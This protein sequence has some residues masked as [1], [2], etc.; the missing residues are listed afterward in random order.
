MVALE[1]LRRWRRTM[2]RVVLVVALALTM[3]LLSV[4]STLAVG[5]QPLPLAAC[6]TGTATA[7]DVD[8]GGAHHIA[9]LH[10]FDSDGTWACYHRNPTYPP[11]GPGLE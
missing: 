7:H 11:P 9:D 5:P 10:D 3:L 1:G 8:A 4:G 6:N 2:K